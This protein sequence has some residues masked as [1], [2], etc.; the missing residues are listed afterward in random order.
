MKDL[1]IIGASGF[2]RETAWLVER[3]NK[4]SASWK[5]LGFMDDA[6][7][8][9]GITVNGYPV[10]GTTAEINRYDAYYVCAVGSAKIRKQIIDRIRKDNEEVRFATLIDPSVE[11]SEHVV[12]GEGSILCAHSIL[13]VNI[14]IGQHVIINLG[15]TIGH[16]VVIGDFVTAY[17]SVNVSGNVKIDDCAELGTGSQIIQ[18]MKIGRGSVLGAGSVVISDIADHSLAAGVPA[19]IIRSI[20]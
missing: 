12:I 18:G 17:P 10:L 20:P 5:L 8:M 16:D 4:I 11:L 6:L 2:G 7:E 3:I 15:C 9:Q 14:E 19:R 13:T 1:V